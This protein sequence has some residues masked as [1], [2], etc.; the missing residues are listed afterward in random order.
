M[1]YPALYII[2]RV[3]EKTEMEKVSS[4]TPKVKTSSGEKKETQGPK[5]STEKSFA[6][7]YK[8]KD[9]AGIMPG[10]KKDGEGESKKLILFEQ[11]TDGE[12][13]GKKPDEKD[14]KL[15]GFA[16][17]RIF[18][19]KTGIENIKET[20]K[21]GEAGIKL[22]ENLINRIVESARIVRKGDTASMEINIKSDVFENLKLVVT[23]EGGGIKTEFIT[24]NPVLREIIKDSMADLE[25]SLVARGLEVLAMVV[26]DVPPAS[27]SEKQYDE[28][29]RLNEQK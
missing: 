16:I 4:T 9:D 6:R 20:Y 21:A 17:P 13:R 14:E 18:S 26:R 29:R 28:Y 27:Q 7:V 22:D 3:K 8:A 19:E 23:A 12:K 25:K 1:K 2:S 11:E 5:Q 15:E 24:E 10:I